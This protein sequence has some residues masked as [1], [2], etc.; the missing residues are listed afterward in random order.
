MSTFAR[1]AIAS[2]SRLLTTPLTPRLSAAVAEHHD[3]LAALLAGRPHP[4]NLPAVEPEPGL[5][6]DP[7]PLTDIQHA[8][9]IG[10][11]KGLELGGV[12]S[13]YYFEFDGTGLD[14]PRLSAALRRSSRGTTCSARWSSP[15]ES[16]GCWSRSRRTR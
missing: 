10:R 2:A 3:R 6:N 4:A 5:R 13:H 14:V 16:S 7:F 8:Y 9:L 1:T 12:S 15:A 11:T